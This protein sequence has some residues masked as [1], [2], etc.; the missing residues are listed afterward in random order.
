MLESHC[1]RHLF[2]REIVKRR[3]PRA[4][5]EIRYRCNAYRIQAAMMQTRTT[6][7]LYHFLK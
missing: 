7:L 3:S 5:L 4:L 2:E 1:C 6:K